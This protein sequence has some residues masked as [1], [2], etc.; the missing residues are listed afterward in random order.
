VQRLIYALAALRAGADAV[1][2]AHVFLEDAQRPVSAHFSAA[3]A[4]ELELE[5]AR[6]S[7]G[8]RRRDFRVT[9]VPHRAICNGCPAEGGLCSWPIEL[10]RREAPD[11]L[12]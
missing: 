10:T 4:A 8:V 11:Q 1:E 2:V 9:D 6:F 12:F 3:D 7:G 5:L